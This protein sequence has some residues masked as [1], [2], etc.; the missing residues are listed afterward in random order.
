MALTALIRGG[1]AR[2]G[3]AKAEQGEAMRWLCIEMIR[4]G[5]A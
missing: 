4:K 3:K 5:I 1:R 2:L